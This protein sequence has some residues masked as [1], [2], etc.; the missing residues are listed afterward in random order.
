[1]KL[2]AIVLF[3]IY[4]VLTGYLTM[5]V[6][7][8]SYKRK[9]NPLAKDGF[10]YIPDNTKAINIS[11]SVVFS[12]NGRIV[13]AN[14]QV[15]TAPPTTSVSITSNFLTRGA[16]NTFV[17][18]DSTQMVSGIQT[19]AFT[20]SSATARVNGGTSATI[21]LFI[22][23]K[24]SEYNISAATPVWSGA[25]TAGTAHTGGTLA[26]VSVAADQC[27]TAVID[28]IAGAVGNIVIWVRGNQ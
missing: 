1:M 25:V 20:I 2:K 24:N 5:G 11:S 14:G 21:R 9:Y 12:G 15:S 6:Y 13:W 8:D 4:V 27:I 3:G 26:N 10:C 28:G 16:T 23:A 17:T 7:A 19:S 22:T 18:T